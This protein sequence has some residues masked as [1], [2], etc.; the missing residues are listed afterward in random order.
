MMAVDLPRI[1]PGDAPQG[2]SL[3]GGSS[4]LWT[5]GEAD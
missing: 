2:P 5:G 4:D 3:L 1:S